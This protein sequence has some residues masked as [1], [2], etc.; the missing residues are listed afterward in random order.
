MGPLMRLLWQFHWP[1]W[2]SLS[3]WSDGHCLNPSHVEGTSQN[4]KSHGW[5]YTQV[6]VG[7]PMCLLWRGHL[8]VLW[9]KAQGMNLGALWGSLVVYDSFYDMTAASQVEVVKP[10][11]PH[12]KDGPQANLWMWMTP[13]NVAFPGGSV[14]VLQ[15]SLSSCE[16][17]ELAW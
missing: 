8:S 11:M 17:R 15:L 7:L 5:M 6:R 12:Q 9:W 3:C 1:K 10:A 4:P 2:W 16:G 14:G 13:V